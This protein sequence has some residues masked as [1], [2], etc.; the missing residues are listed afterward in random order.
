MNTPDWN[1]V[2]PTAIGYLTAADAQA[3]QSRTLDVCAMSAQQGDAA[4]VAVYLRPIPQQPEPNQWG[5]GYG[6]CRQFVVQRLCSQLPP[7]DA[8]RALKALG[9]PTDDESLKAVGVMR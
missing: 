9:W 1:D 6:E 4:D 2:T 7:A 8:I 5:A 3:L